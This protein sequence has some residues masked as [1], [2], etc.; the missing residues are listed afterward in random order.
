MEGFVSLINPI[1]GIKYIGGINDFLLQ[2][3]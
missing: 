2:K 1:S 3:P